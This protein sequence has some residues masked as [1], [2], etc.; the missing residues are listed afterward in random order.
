VE[1]LVRVARRVGQNDMVP[2]TEERL[3]MNDP[4]VLS[5]FQADPFP[6][7]PPRFARAVL[8]Q[9]WFTS[10]EDKRRTGNWWRRQLLGLYA[11]EITLTPDGKPEIVQWADE[12]PPHD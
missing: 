8:W 4:D 5:L 7:S 1:S 6:H 10:M 12:L 11:P 2:L 3:L 9:Y